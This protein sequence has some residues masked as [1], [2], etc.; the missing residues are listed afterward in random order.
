MLF[1][2]LG[3]SMAAYH[4]AGAGVHHDSHSEM[5]DGQTHPALETNPH[6]WH[7][8]QVSWEILSWSDCNPIQ[9][10]THDPSLPDGDSRKTSGIS[11]PRWHL[12]R[13]SGREAGKGSLG[14][15]VLTTFPK[16]SVIFWCTDVLWLMNYKGRGTRG[17]FTWKGKVTHYII[18]TV[19]ES[20]DSQYSS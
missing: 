14:T 17:Q 11:L 19:L 5:A 15:Q 12:E 9:R 8:H 7:R 20:N 1:L 4:T 3:F 2:C 18:M 10:S 13:S 16:L 6:P